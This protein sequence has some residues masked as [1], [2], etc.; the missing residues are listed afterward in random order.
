[1]CVAEYIDADN[2]NGYGNPDR[3]KI[4]GAIRHIPNLPG[5]LLR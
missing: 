4:E 5:K 2:N 1:M 3:S